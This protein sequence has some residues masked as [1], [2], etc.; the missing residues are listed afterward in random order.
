MRK[1]E[2][3]GPVFELLTVQQEY[4]VRAVALVLRNLAL[5]ERCKLVIGMQQ[6]YTLCCYL[7]CYKLCLFL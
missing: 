4:V 1:Q 6:F 3:L 7:Y 2:G 5:E